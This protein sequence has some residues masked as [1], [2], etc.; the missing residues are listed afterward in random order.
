MGY[1]TRTVHCT[2]CGEPMTGKYK[3]S[4]PW[5]CVEC[6]IAAAIE[7]Q[8]EQAERRGPGYEKWLVGM[9]KAGERARRQLA[10]RQ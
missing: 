5:R 1:A 10:R 7:A 4:P 2:T 8:R 9:A 3:P 6:G